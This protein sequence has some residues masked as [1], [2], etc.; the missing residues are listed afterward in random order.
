MWINV[1]AQL[2]LATDRFYA[3]CWDKEKTKIFEG[4][5]VALIMTAGADGYMSQDEI[6]GTTMD[7]YEIWSFKGM[8]SIGTILGQG[9]ESEAFKLG[10]S[11]R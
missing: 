9:K 7:W 3:Y 6:Y 11:I 2:R 8:K 1:S 5:Q 10:T 4:K